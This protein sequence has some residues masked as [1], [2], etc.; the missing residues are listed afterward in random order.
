MNLNLFFPHMAAHDLMA[1]NQFQ[2]QVLFSF[3]ERVCSMKRTP[4][5]IKTQVQ[6][7]TDW[8]RHFDC[9]LSSLRW[10]SPSSSFEIPIFD[11][12]DTTVNGCC[13]FYLSFDYVHTVLCS[14]CVIDEIAIVFHFLQHNKQIQTTES[15]KKKNQRILSLVL[16]NMC[17]TNQF[18]ILHCT[19][20][21][22]LNACN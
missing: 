10:S 22:V 21:T 3:C 5:A 13:L 8:L 19:L 12:T 14:A 11:R 1:A 20:T 18:F 17:R 7:P 9:D 15:M 16:T 6:L 2:C 4:H